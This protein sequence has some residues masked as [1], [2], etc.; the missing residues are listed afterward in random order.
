ML[1]ALDC[2]VQESDLKSAQLAQQDAELAAATQE[3]AS[4]LA[5]HQH[6]EKVGP[7]SHVHILLCKA[8]SPFK[9]AMKPK[10][11]RITLY[12]CSEFR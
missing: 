7:V 9:Q 4:R 12:M 11:I 10:V 8:L 2:N 3:V 5:A 1:M 6:L